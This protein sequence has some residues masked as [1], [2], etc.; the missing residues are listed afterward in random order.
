MFDALKIAKT[1]QGLANLRDGGHHNR[2]FV[3]YASCR[4]ARICC[5][6]LTKRA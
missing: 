2:R 3:S 1:A 6:A 4:K 5:I